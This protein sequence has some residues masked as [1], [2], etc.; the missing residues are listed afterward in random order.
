MARKKRTLKEW[1]IRNLMTQEAFAE[2]VGVGRQIVIAWEKGRQPSV[3][4]IARIEQVL[5]ISYFDDVIV[6]KE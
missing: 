4:N 6:P 3:K 5:N 1:R 2:A